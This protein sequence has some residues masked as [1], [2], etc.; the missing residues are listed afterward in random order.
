MI[1][2]NAFNKIRWKNLSQEN[3]N[4]IFS[5]SKEV[6]SSLLGANKALEDKAFSYFKLVYTILIAL[7]GY[8]ITAQGAE[9]YF[10]FV[11]T[12]IIVCIIAISYLKIAITPV[13]ATSLGYDTN[14]FMAEKDSKAMYELDNSEVLMIL[15]YDYDSRIR[16][17]RKINMEISSNLTKAIFTLIGG[18]AFCGLIG[19]LIAITSLHL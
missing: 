10:L 2:T 12:E 1:M 11:F 14:N 17:E 3:A 7:V 8:L 13:S 18:S 15:A 4:L 9:K 5:E 19:L 6:L 16:I